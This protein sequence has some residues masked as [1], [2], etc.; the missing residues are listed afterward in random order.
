MIKRKADVVDQTTKGI[1]YLMSKNKITR[2]EGEASFKDKTTLSIK[3]GKK[4]TEISGKKIM[5][6]TGSDVATLP[7]LPID[8]KRIISSTEALE[9]KSV[10]KHLIIVGGGVIGVELG[11]VYARLGSKVTVVEFMPNL[12]PTMDKELGKHLERSLKKLGFEFDL[13]LYDRRTGM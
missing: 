11:S 1:D 12:I 8:G 6:A 4:T 3:S 13:I 10:P 9:L 5:I 7:F 2:F